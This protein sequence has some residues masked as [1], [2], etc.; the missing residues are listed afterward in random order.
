MI[1]VISGFMFIF[2]GDKPKHFQ[3][4]KKILTAISS[5]IVFGKVFV[6]LV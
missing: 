3:R 6:T 2:L 1:L 4:I 5:E